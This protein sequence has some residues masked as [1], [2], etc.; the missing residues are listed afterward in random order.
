MSKKLIG[1]GLL[2]ASSSAF[3]AYAINE[4]VKAPPQAPGA[5][6]V[7]AGPQAPGGS[8]GASLA[9]QP[10]EGAALVD[11]CAPIR[12]AIDAARLQNVA[13]I[14]G[15]GAGE[16]C[17][18]KKG[19]IEYNQKLA[20]ASATKLLTGILSYRMIQAGK[21]TANAKPQQYFGYWT[22]SASDNRSKITLE[23]LL[24]FTSGFNTKDANLL[25][26]VYNAY[27]TLDLCIRRI[28]LGNLDSVPG[29]V[30][31][32][33]P[34][35]M[36]VAA[37]MLD[38]A[39]TGDFGAIFARYVT[40]PLGLTN[41]SYALQ[42]AANPWAAAGGESTAEDYAVIMQ[43][44]FNG[45]LVTDLNNFFAPRTLTATKGEVPAAILANNG[46]QWEY[47][48]GSWV[49]CEYG[50]GGAN[51]ATQCANDKINSSPGAW[52]FTP[53]ID[54]QNGYWALIATEDH[55]NGAEKGVELEQ[56]LQPL[57]VAAL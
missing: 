46:S 30:Y 12:A 40:T 42:S 13:V 51:Y 21:I 31:F 29:A 8:A 28:Y 47:A 43:A 56:V 53:W 26:C 48:Q 24:A 18:Y 10:Q 44:L 39:D 45:T 33:G 3:A 22:N 20:L 17:R 54:R 6:R 34:H 19:A 49:E 11:N 38:A 27:T 52:G 23:Q 35:H 25:S 50:T 1:A 7:A 37:G 32:Y 5:V 4:A 41:T 55:D 16:I 9:A 57:M 2:F 14:F 15:N 36:Q